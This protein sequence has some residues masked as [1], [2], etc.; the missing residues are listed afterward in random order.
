LGAS[1]GGTTVGGHQGV[2]SRASSLITPPNGGAGGGSCLPSMVALAISLLPL[3][4]SDE[5]LKL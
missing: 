2:E 3:Q 5:D 4:I 1:F